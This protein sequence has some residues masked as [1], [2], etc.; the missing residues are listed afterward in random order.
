MLTLTVV[1]TL[2]AMV[3][4]A[5]IL[6]YLVWNGLSSIHLTTFTTGPTPIGTP[7]GGLKNG[8]VG[9][10]VLLGIASC[11]GLPLGIL[12]GIYQLE[13]G[14]GKVSGAVRFLTDVLNSIPS[15]IVGI[16]VYVIVV[17]PIARAHPGEGY[18]A[19]A[20]GIALG[21]LM[22]PTIMRSTEE[23]LRLVPITLRDG[24]LALGSTRWRAM[25]HVTL[26]AARGGIITGI[27]L[28]L[29]RVAGE[30][31][32][33]LF[34]AFGNSQFNVKPTEPIDAL[35]L[36][37]FTDAQSAYD[38]L[39]RLAMGGALILVGIIL[40]LSLIARRFARRALVIT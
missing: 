2:I 6:G 28:A 8:I 31:A 4:L 17:L 36:D 22:V 14:G 27:M 15:I 39:H 32:P 21:I 30:T 16:F 25:W 5:L 33:L 9:T 19:M 37:I 35:P 10:L 23:M 40:C 20:G 24:A 26:P 38:Y 13:F 34:T 29:A 12:G 1:A 18:S 7:G 11:I 3:P